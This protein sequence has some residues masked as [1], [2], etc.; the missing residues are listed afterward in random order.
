MLPFYYV[1]ILFL[2]FGRALF[3]QSFA[4]TTPGQRLPGKAE[5][6]R[7]LFRGARNAGCGMNSALHVS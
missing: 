2:C 7:N 4:P 3:G 1:H 6:A 5:E